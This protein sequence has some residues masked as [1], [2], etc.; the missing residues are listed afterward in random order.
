MDNVK[1]ITDPTTY[2]HKAITFIA[3]IFTEKYYFAKFVDNSC[4]LV[5]LNN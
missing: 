4:I 2:I 1:L 3:V 5:I